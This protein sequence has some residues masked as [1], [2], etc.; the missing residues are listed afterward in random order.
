MLPSPASSG[1]GA[2]GFKIPSPQP[3]SRRAGEGHS[4]GG[5][6]SIIDENQRAPP[7]P[8]SVGEGAGG[9]RECS[10]PRSVGEGFILGERTLLSIGWWW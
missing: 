6:P 10:R 2:L 3:L 9:V 1:R 8:R 5:S 7:R 4:F